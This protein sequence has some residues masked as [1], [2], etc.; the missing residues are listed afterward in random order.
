MHRSKLEIYEEVLKAL[1]KK[2]L[3]I[4]SLAYE[5]NMDCVLLSQRLTFLVK[6]DLIQQGTCKGQ[7]VYALT[8][9]GLAIS[10]TLALTRRLEKLQTTKNSLGDAVQALPALSGYS[11]GKAKRT[12]R[13]ENY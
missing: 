13:S 11:E 1:A 5:C 3:T 2:P 6:N 10:K 7:T 9:R 8:K 12:R 4:D